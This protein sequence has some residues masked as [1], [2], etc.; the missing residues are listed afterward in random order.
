M[1]EDR[2][3]MKNGGIRALE[4]REEWRKEDEK[5]S[6]TEGEK[7]IEGDERRKERR[8]GRG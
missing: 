5:R 1:E 6:R 4:E 8:T 3:K 7:G 2:K